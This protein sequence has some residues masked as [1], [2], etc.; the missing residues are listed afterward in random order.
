MFRYLKKGGE[1]IIAL[2]GLISWLFFVLAF[3]YLVVNFN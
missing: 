3:I 1:L 2:T